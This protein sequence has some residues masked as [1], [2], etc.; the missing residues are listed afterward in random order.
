MFTSPS[1]FHNIPRTN[2]LRP[3]LASF[4]L[5]A[6]LLT[7]M[8]VLI[9]GQKL[10]LA[11]TIVSNCN[12]SNNSPVPG[13]LRYA[14]DQ[15]GTITF[16]C[17]GTL[18][19]PEQYVISLN[20]TLDANGHNI[21][22]SG[23]AKHRVFWI[24][25][26]VILTLKNLAIEDGLAIDP[27]KGPGVKEGG[28]IVNHGGTLKAI[29]VHFNNNLANEGG[30]IYSYA[31]GTVKLEQ[32][33]FIKNKT[34]PG[35]YWNPT[36]GG[37]IFTQDGTLEVNNTIFGEN[38]GYDGGAIA[39]HQANV[40]IKGS[41]FEGNSTHPTVNSKSNGDG[42]ATQVFDA[43]G[44]SGGAIASNQA[45]TINDST[46][47]YNTASYDGGAIASTGGYISGS[48]FSSNSA[49]HNNGGAIRNSG[50][51]YQI[52]LS[53][54][55]ENKALH[56]EGGAIFNGYKSTL[57]L[58]QTTLNNNQTNK[59]G[60]AL[61]N[62]G[63]YLEISRSALYNNQGQE[64]GGAIY[65]R[66]GWTRLI[67]S[68]VANNS[69]NQ[70]SALAAE[71]GAKVDLVNATVASDKVVSSSLIFNQKGQVNLKNSLVAN[72]YNGL[73]CTGDPVVDGGYN[74]QYPASSCGQTIAVKNP[75]LL[76][77]ANYG[78]PTPTMALDLG[79]P[80]IDAADNNVCNA[81][82]VNGID[83]RGNPR[84]TDG[85]LDNK[86]VCDI[87]AFEAPQLAY[88]K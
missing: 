40:M 76:P 59:M 67:N 35:S 88:K 32:S 28:A 45:V 55:S 77:L 12:S 56:G 18:A 22:I 8:L 87:G 26:N 41:T 25:P 53:A 57:T 85:N 16:S 19:L 73:N 65:S 47:V 31:N 71:T 7:T 60:G 14:L 51:T 4:Y 70:G 50:G 39:N 27:N 9:P 44:A 46:F 61:S 68:T 64:R 82:P 11:A 20:T 29:N 23:Q 5:L 86:A 58:S 79:S 33:F 66:S 24:R 30:A 1:K 34:L 80:A 6:T 43:V 15:G 37:A 63:F 52:Y 49:A 78:G 36:D 42:S 69:S 72:Y 74:L 75:K 83:Q 62:N 10:A 13:N 38:K 17:S 21:T 84:P 3:V 48:N 54:F 2:H 81:V